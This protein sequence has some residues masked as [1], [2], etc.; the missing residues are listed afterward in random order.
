MIQRPR[1]GWR[2]FFVEFFFGLPNLLG[3][4]SIHNSKQN[5]II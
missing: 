5:Y 1:Q 4:T 2:G 3:F